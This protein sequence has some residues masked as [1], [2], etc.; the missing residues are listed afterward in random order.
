MAASG[1]FFSKILVERFGV[2]E[3][4]P[5]GV[6]LVL[7]VGVLAVLGGVLGFALSLRWLRGR[8]LNP[9]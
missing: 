4:P 5:A 7:L 9:Q 6:L 2:V 3:G 8:P 1:S